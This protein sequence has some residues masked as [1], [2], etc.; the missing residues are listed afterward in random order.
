MG[1]FGSKAPVPMTADAAA[2]KPGMLDIGL[3][4]LFGG[5][6]PADAAEHLRELQFQNATRPLQAQAM[7]KWMGLFGG[8]APQGGPQG[9][10]QAQPA[11]DPGPQDLPSAMSLGLGRATGASPPPSPPPP[12]QTAAPSG[13]DINDPATQQMLFGG[14]AFGMPGAK[15][16][17]DIAKAVQ[18]D[19]GYD[20]GFGFNRKTGRDMGGFHPDLGQGVGMNAGRAEAV[21]GYAD[22]AAQIAGATAGAQEQQKAAWDLVDVPMADGSTVK[23]PRAVAAPMLARRFSGAGPAGPAGPVGGAAGGFGQSQTPGAKASAEAVGRVEG[24]A[25]ANARVNNPSTMARS[26]SAVGIIDD[27]LTDPGLADRTGWRSKLPAMPGSH[28][29]SVDAKIDQLGGQVFL[30]AYQEL[31]GAGAITEVEG[32]KAENAIARLKRRDQSYDDYRGAL[33][34]LR[35]VISGGMTRAQMRAAMGGG[36]RASSAPPNRSAVEAEMRRRGLLH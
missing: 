1:M 4:M 27:L 24:E 3:Q 18:P 20:R 28:G 34:D 26:E 33:K 14:A 35:G 22:A 10:P 36:D 11:P 19:V 32:Q 2:Y 30:Q 5:Q 16:A 6:A 13:F 21:P 12:P 29:V 15:E 17:L 25:G 7:Q 31:K 23:L 8:S 9:A